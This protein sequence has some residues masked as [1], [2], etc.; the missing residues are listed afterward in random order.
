MARKFVFLLAM[1]LLMVAPAT[2]GLA[3]PSGLPVDVP[4]NELFVAD[5]IYRYNAGIGNYN[6]W[7]TA[8]T[9]HRHALMMQTLWYR[10]QETGER[11]YAAAVSDPEY[12]EDFT[13]MTVHLRDNI[14]WSDD[15]QFT[16]DDLVFTV[17]TLMA[18]PSLT[19]G[20]WSATLN[21]FVESVEKVDDFT[22]LFTFKVSDPRFHS[23]FEAQWN[24]VYM[25]PKHVIE[26]VPADDLATWKFENP[27]V[28]GAYI[29]TQF[30]PNGFWELYERRDDWERTPPGIIVG[31]EG[32]KYVL[33]IFY[34]DSSKKAIAMSRGE[35]DTFF[36]ADYEAFQSVLDTTPTARSWYT[37]FPWAYPN[38]NAT[39]QF[40]FNGETDPIYNIKD[41]RWALA[42]SLNIVELQTEYIGG[43]AKVAA[44]PLAPVAAL[45]GL[46]YEPMEEWLQNLQIEVAPGEMFNVYDPTIGEQ[47]A[48]WAEEQG[49]TVPG[50]PVEVFGYGWWKFAPDVAERLLTNN[51]FSRDGSGNWLKPDGTPWTMDLQAAPDENDA[52]RMATAASDMWSEFGIDVNLQ[53]LER[54]IWDQNRQV[55]QF[56]VNTPWYSIANP[57]GDGW[58]VLQQLHPKYYVPNGEDTR[59]TGAGWYNI[60]RINDPQLG[61]MIDAMQPL[62]PDSEENHQAVIDFTKYITENMLF[63]TAISFKKFTTWDE[64]YWTGFP[65]SEEP[66]YQPLYWFQG[67]AMAFQSLRPVTQ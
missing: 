14:Y 28:L 9:P 12:N 34:G 56:E 1:V 51:G 33:T 19:Q 50:D 8:D 13:Q 31:N 45:K 41:V 6:L 36:D 65:T 30:D 66:N 16:A 37:E 64:R 53:G 32:P 11:L 59:A 39:R 58:P 4:R 55:G 25:M 17:E 26:T 49:Y 21:E 18:N 57:D 27:V 35:L 63:M 42:L 46:Y 67:G 60:M 47:I 15:V 43:V 3:Q 44:L 20:G 23:L 10:D 52:F 22:V 29:P 2:L 5:Q 40:V 24:G 61:E 54:S 48:A 7:G 62:F 38:E